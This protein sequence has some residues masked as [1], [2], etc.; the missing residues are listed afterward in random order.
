[1]RIGIISDTHDLLRPTAVEALGGVDRIVHVGDVCNGSIL[2]ELRQIAPLHCVLGNCDHG[3]WTTEWPISDTIEFEGIW[4]HAR[5]I[6][7]QVDLDPATAGIAIVLS[8]HTHRP[9]R[10]VVDGVTYFNPGSAGPR[11]FSLPISLGML[12]VQG[13]TFELRWT[14]LGE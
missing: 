2:E 14:T 11:R 1:M 8:G 12:E 6:R 10:D 13:E 5:H 4:V 9:S 7:E 3:D